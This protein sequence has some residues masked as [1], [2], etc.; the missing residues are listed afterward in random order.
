MSSLP[1]LVFALLLFIIPL[2]SRKDDFNSSCEQ[3]LASANQTLKCPSE[4]RQSVIPQ[5]SEQDSKETCPS[6]FYCQK[7]RCKCLSHP[8]HVLICNNASHSA[9]ILNCYCMTQ[10]E[11]TDMIFVGACLYN[12]GSRAKGLYHGE[13]SIYSHLPAHLNEICEEMNRT[14]ALCGKCMPNYYPLAYS[15]SWQCIQCPNHG[16]NWLKYIAAAY[17]PLTLFCVIIILF[18][19]NLASSH[20]YPVVTYCQIL[21]LPVSSRIAL[22]YFDTHASTPAIVGLKLLLSLYGIWNLDFFRP[23][24]SDICLGIDVLPTLALDYIIAL[25]PL[26]FM[27]ISY[28]LIGLY[29]KNYRIITSL[30]SP[31]QALLSKFR[32]HWNIRTSVIDAF[33]TFFLLS[34]IKF[35]S[36]SFDLL[37]PT[38]VYQI[39]HGHRNYT[40]ALYYAAE[41]EYFGKEHLP[42]AILAI[43]VLAIFV[44]LPVIVTIFYP[45]KLF[46][47]ILN[48][49]PARWYILHIF[50]DSFQ[51]CYK[52]GTEPGTYDC[53]WFHSVYFLSRFL[54]FIVYG[55]TVSMVFFIA[56]SIP[57]MFTV[58]TILVVRPFKSS[59]AYYNWIHAIF[60]QFL[61]L[62]CVTIAA[63]NMAYYFTYH[64]YTFIV[65]SGVLII[66]PIV[67]SALLVL[68]FILK[69]R[70]YILKAITNFKARRTGYSELSETSNEETL[71]NHEQDPK[72]NLSNFS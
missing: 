41:I 9:F 25:Y 63:A 58:L 11:N 39:Y 53:R 3:C 54:L 68:Y 71:D 6:G 60:A 21:A 37:I 26:L 2:S 34:N 38:R 30:W 45:F 42:Y 15:F 56:A 48:K 44:L 23:F 1:V 7:G 36:V 55:L 69:S 46:Q 4:K 19:V 8:K 65:I 32:R 47:K 62:L 31:F 28:A 22:N 72:W 5:C 18:K 29:D 13:T 43:A 51:G 64:Y 59:I 35:L 16:M 50:M 14:G 57:L 27:I 12:C 52:D 67:Y 70:K 33:A 17:L 40:T 66:A 10:D 20:Y 61:A 24:Y 49:F